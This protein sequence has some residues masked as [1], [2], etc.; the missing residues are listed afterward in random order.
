MRNRRKNA[1]H[2][3][4]K[5]R[6]N[7][8]NAWLCR[9][10]R[11]MYVTYQVLFNTKNILGFQAFGI[12]I[13]SE[14]QYK[15]IQHALFDGLLSDHVDEQGRVDYGAIMHDARL[16]AYIDMLSRVSPQ[17]LHE[18]E[19]LAFW[20]NAYN[21]YTIKLVVDNYPIGSIREITPFRIKGLQLAIPK[22]NSPFEY[23]IAS[24]GG[25]EYSLDDIEHSILRKVFKEP[26]IH[27]ALVC[28]SVSCPSLRREAYTG[29]R[30]DDQLEDQ[31]RRFLHDVTK[32]RI[33]LASNTLYL[34]QIFNWFRKDFASSK[35]KLQEYLSAFWGGEV[36]QQLKDQAFVIKH[37]PYNWSLND[38]DNRST[39]V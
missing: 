22:L 25:K 8:S 36:A 38:Q 12:R 4:L 3:C 34:S 33:N 37:L 1:S 29:I 24:I 11:E 17:E 7:H 16:Q 5:I 30:L 20:I 27:F 23:R 13:M 35:G 10:R 14:V 19:A 28:A 18:N 32:N 9:V 26:R 39:V 6:E 2:N 15:A 21:V 31:A